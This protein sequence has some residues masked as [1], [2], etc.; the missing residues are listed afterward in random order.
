MST[1]T[2]SLQYSTTSTPEHPLAAEIE[3]LNGSSNKIKFDANPNIMQQK[4]LVMGR[5][6]GTMAH[7]VDLEHSPTYL[8]VRNEGKTSRYT[9]R[10]KCFLSRSFFYVNPASGLW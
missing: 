8:L 10:W 2:K 9:R 5:L 1:E 6:E 4:L 3:T 7:D